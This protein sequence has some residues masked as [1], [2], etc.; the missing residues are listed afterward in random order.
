MFPV[1]FTSIIGRIWEI[2][3]HAFPF[4]ICFIFCELPPLIVVFQE[5]QLVKIFC[6]S[7]AQN[8]STKQSFFSASVSRVGLNPKV[9]YP[10]E[11]KEI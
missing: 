1:S 7:L 11:V 10:G 9:N 5:K 8:P 6:F 2:W 3:K 4:I